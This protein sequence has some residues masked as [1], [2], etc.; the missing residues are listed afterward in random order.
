LT[1]RKPEIT[2]QEIFNSFS[3]TLSDQA[4]SDNGVTVDDEVHDTDNPELGKLR[5]DDEP[6]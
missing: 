4:S 5:T 2:F 6:C 3:D 1:T